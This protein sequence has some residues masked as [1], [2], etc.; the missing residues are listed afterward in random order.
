MWVKEFERLFIARTMRG[1]FTACDGNG[2]AGEIGKIFPVMINDGF[3]VGF[4]NETQEHQFPGSIER[5]LE[6]H[7]CPL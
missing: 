6:A 2:H 7:R 3:I 4:I 1:K 5:L